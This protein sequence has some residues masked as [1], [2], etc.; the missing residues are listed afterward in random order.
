MEAVVKLRRSV[1]TIFSAGVILA[2]VLSGALMAAPSSKATTAAAPPAKA[3]PAKA[4][5]AAAKPAAI[6]HGQRPV[7]PN[8]NRPLIQDPKQT[9]GGSPHRDPVSPRISPK[10]NGGQPI[11]YQ[12]H[13]GEQQKALPGGR[14]EFHNSQT[15]STVR[16]N[17]QGHV[18]QIECRRPGLGGGSI[19]VSRSAHGQ[20]MVVTGRPG[21]RVVS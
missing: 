1:E 2:V 5:P 17:A 16:T 20:R 21:A 7:G 15:G 9:P 11:K 6:Q 12:P 4:A 14:T 8:A 13:V 10:I 3:A 19:A 18:T